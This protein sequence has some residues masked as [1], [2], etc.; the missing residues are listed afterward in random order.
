MQTITR[1][2]VYV[3]ADR[4]T[5]YNFCV[6]TRPLFTISFLVPGYYVRPGSRLQ[7][8]HYDPVTS[9]D[10]ACLCLYFLYQ[11][12]TLPQAWPVF[13]I[14][15]LLTVCLIR[16]IWSLSSILVLV[17]GYYNQEPQLAASILASWCSCRWCLHGAVLIHVS[18][19]GSVILSCDDL[20]SKECN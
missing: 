13:V 16:Q 17:S 15:V 4:T 14:H 19:Q 20:R 3:L 9:R 10:H 11:F 7:V 12:P 18:S 5:V 6:R 1:L 2:Y 8:V